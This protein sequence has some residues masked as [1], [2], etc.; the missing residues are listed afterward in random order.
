MLVGFWLGEAADRL[1]SDAAFDDA[2][3]AE[4]RALYVY[5]HDRI[6]CDP[7][8]ARY[9]V[10]LLCLDQCDVCAVAGLS[11]QLSAGRRAR[12]RTDRDDRDCSLAG[13][14]RVAWPFLRGDFR[15]ELSTAAS[16]HGLADLGVI[17]ARRRLRARVARPAD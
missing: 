1:E 5:L 2:G 13:P 8:N 14:T 7:N 17:R 11:A 10:A 3:R 16:R 9:I 15:K 6:V 12:A 4:R